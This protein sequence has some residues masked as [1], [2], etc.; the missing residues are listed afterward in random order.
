MNSTLKFTGMLAFSLLFSGQSVAGLIDRGNGMIYDDILD[1]TWLQDANYAHTSGYSTDNAIGS[2]DGAPLNVQTDGK[3]GWQ[4]AMNW[5]E[6]LAFG[7]FDD[8]RLASIKPLNGSNFSYGNNA[9]DGSADFGFNITSTQS[10]LAYMFNVNLGLE[11]LFTTDDKFNPDWVLFNDEIIPDTGLIKNLKGYGYW[12][13][14]EDFLNTNDAWLFNSFDG[15][16]TETGKGSSFYA[17]AVRDG[18]VAGA[19]SVSVSEPASI[20]LFGLGLLGLSLRFRRH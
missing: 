15:R 4:A 6:N 11:S 17:W 3:M 14:T 18:D 1:I 2:K 5:A 10:E 12:S 8:W 19:P 7:G 20:A 16:Q 9:K 13:D